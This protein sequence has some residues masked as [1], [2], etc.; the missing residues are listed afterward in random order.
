MSDDDDDYDDDDDDD[1]DD[2]DDDDDDESKVHTLKAY[3]RNRNTAPLLHN[4]VF[5]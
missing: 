4:F 5:R 2:D 3:M 1:Y